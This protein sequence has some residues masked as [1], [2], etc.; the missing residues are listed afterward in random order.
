MISFCQEIVLH[1]TKFFLRR[2]FFVKF[3]IKNLFRKLSIKMCLKN[4]TVKIYISED[5]TQINQNGPNVLVE[6]INK[7]C[8][9]L[10]LAN[11]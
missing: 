11:F 10:F 8:L 3:S 9:H 4:F 6:N 5:P 1:S 7:T 2:I